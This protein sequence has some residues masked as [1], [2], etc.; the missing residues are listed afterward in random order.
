MGNIHVGESYSKY[1]FD[2][3]NVAR[4]NIYH[5]KIYYIDIGTERDYI[6]TPSSQF[7]NNSYPRISSSL[8]K[9]LKRKCDKMRMLLNI[10]VILQDEVV[11][12]STTINNRVSSSQSSISNV[13]YDNNTFRFVKNLFSRTGFGDDSSIMNLI[14]HIKGTEISHYNKKLI[15][16]IH[17]NVEGSSN[18]Q[19]EQL[20]VEEKIL[21]EKYQMIHS[22]HIPIIPNI[23]S[24]ILHDIFNLSEKFPKNGILSM[25]SFC[26]TES[27][28]INIPK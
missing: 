4:F 6:L 28:I 13:D 18:V 10:N 20:P 7:S 9:I 22:L 3:F 16:L 5:M 25:K 1:Y 26:G 11:D 15:N 24:T 23:M 19:Y 14:K 21:K 12:T 27:A 2:K 8:S 17:M